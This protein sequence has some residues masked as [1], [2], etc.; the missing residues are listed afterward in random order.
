MSHSKIKTWIIGNWKKNPASLEEVTALVTN[1]KNILTKSKTQN[2][3]QSDCANL[4]FVPSTL[5]IIPVKSL[6]ADTEILVGCQD[7]SSKSA[8][9]GAYTGD[10]SAQQ[11]KESGVSW[12]LVGHSERREYHRENNEVL[13]A[14]LQ[15]AYKQGLGVV[16]CIGETLTEY[17]SKKT[18][19]VL[20]SQLAVIKDFVAVELAKI[21]GDADKVLSDFAKKII[22][23]YEPVWAIG[24][25]KVPTVA[26]V[27]AVNKD[28]RQY[29]TSIHAS[30]M[31]VSI[32]YGGSVSPD[33]AEQFA[34]S[35]VINGA[36]VGGASLVADKFLSIAETF[37]TIKS[38]QS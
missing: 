35:D 31:P 6:I 17:D 30:L 12:S 26:E 18:I 21:E 16:F 19:E 25:G 36:L 28:I 14:K 22:I 37:F 1:T 32:L 15:H 24:T 2:F 5:H 27:E 4:M 29:L 3:L 33:N 13:T 8:T 10:C 34:S 20:H 11:M 23:A 38:E 7:I 9:V